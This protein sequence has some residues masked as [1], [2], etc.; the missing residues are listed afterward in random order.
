MIT[1]CLAYAS[2]ACAVRF[3]CVDDERGILAQHRFAGERERMVREIVALAR[4][5]GFEP[6]R[7]VFS[8]RVMGAIRKVASHRFVPLTQEPHAYENQPMSIGDRQTI[9]QFYIVAL[10][11]DLFDSK[12]G[13]VVLEV[14]T[15][16][17]YP[18]RSVSRPCISRP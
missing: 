17:G 16:S 6:G 5:T 15:G 12:P 2:Y 3:S 4:E 18:R 7:P 9:S 1:V 8:K 10:M 14:G 11:T 13:D